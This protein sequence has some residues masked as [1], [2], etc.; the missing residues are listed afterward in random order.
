MNQ[1]NQEPR[2]TTPEES[3]DMVGEAVSF[4]PP[5]SEPEEDEEGSDFPIEGE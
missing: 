1:A 4:E 2:D 3:W 5:E